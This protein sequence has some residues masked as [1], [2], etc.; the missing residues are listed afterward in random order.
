MAETLLDKNLAQLRRTEPEL[1]ERLRTAEPGAAT[2]L[3]WSASKAGPLTAAVTQDGKPIALASRYDPV[4]EAGKLIEQVDLKRHAGVVALGMGLGYHVSLLAERMSAGA[5]LLIVYEPDLPLLRAVLERID[6]SAWLGRFNVILADERM[7]RAALIARIEPFSGELTQGTIL[8]THPPSRQRFGPQLAAF[9]QLVTDALGYCKTNVATALVNASRTIHNLAL[10]LP[11]YAAG[12]MTD[13]LFNAARGCPAVCVGAGPSLAKNVALLADPAVRRNVVVV[14]AQTTLKP[15]LDRGI[16]P[17]FVTALDYSGISTRFYEGLPPLPGVTLVAEPLAH[18]SILE[19]FPG[20]KR[21]THHRFLD[22][23][24]GD[25]ARPSV[26]IAPGSTVAHLSFYLAQHLGCDPIILIGQDLGF[27]DGLYYCP[28]T[29]IH[30]VWAP[31]LGA[32][33]TLEMMEWQRVVRHRN[34]L[35]KVPDIDGRDIYSDEQMLTYH[36][37]FERDFAQATQRVIDASEGGMAKE[38][39]VR[40]PLAEALRQ[41]ALQ[42]APTLPMPREGFDAQRL[43]QVEAFIARLAEE[44][45]DLRRASRR[46]LP[47]LKEMRDHHEDQARV[48]RLYDRITPLRRRVEQLQ[49]AF[50]VVNE[51]N[52]VG[53]FKRVRADRAIEHAKAGSLEEQ[54]L[55]LERDVENVDWLIQSCDEASRIFREARQNL[56]QRR[57]DAKE[58]LTT[59]TRRHEAEGEN[60][61]RDEKVGLKSLKA[62]AALWVI[63]ALCSFGLLFF[64]SSCLRGFPTIA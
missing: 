33:N 7:D 41:Y 38:H 1:A 35:Q 25:L 55:R 16:E 5:A 30:D 28:G 40:M 49:H 24:L 21:V 53:V 42:P 47:L 26:P 58:E 27:S 18:P 56:T 64:V 31:E 43:Q 20:P 11:Y 36:K 17:D 48:N 62:T 2:G 13:D 15:L 12:A 59:N 14:S 39:T 52:T 60:D 46:T 22:K 54:R 50:M 4:A 3:E 10:N 6:H 63:G 8:I 29:A 61:G 45:D 44:I 51:L 9:G 19:A 57:K 34:H 32:F 37:Q 23:L